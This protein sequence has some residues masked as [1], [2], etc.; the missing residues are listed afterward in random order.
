[1]ARKYHEGKHMMLKEDKSKPSN[2]PQEYM[3][4]EYPMCDYLDTEY[5]DSIYGIDRQKDSDVRGA[6]SQMARKKY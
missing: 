5:D 4:K 1:M 2:L 3:N 6:K